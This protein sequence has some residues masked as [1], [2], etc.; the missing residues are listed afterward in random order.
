MDNQEFGRQLE[1]LL[2][3]AN[4]KNRTIAQ[5]LRYDV[6]YISK[7]ISGKAVPSRKNASDICTAIVSA[8]TENA[9]SETTDKLVKAYGV[10]DPS[11]LE[12]TIEKALL[13]AYY[14]SI[15]ES[16]DERYINNA[17]LALD[18]DES[19][20]IL[21]EYCN[22]TDFSGQI[23]IAIMADLFAISHMGK[24]MLSGIENNHFKVKEPRPDIHLHFVIDISRLDGRSV[25]DVILLIH[26]LTGYSPVDFSLSQNEIAAGKIMVA[27]KEDFGGISLLDGKGGFLATSVARDNRMIKRLYDEIL[28]FE[29]PERFIFSESSIDQLLSNHDYIQSLL[30]QNVRW[31][32]GKMTEQFITDDLF[33]QLSAQVFGDCDY[34]RDEARKA[35]M[36]SNRILEEGET[37]VMIYESALTG[38]MLFGELDFFNNKVILTPEQR[39]VQLEHIAVL[40]SSEKL[41][42]RLVDGGFSDDFRF[43]TNPC[44]FLA[45][46][47]DYLRLDNNYYEKNI[48]LVRDRKMKD[49]FDTFFEQIWTKREDVVIEDK[50]IIA[51]KME[52]LIEAAALLK[53]VE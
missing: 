12:E 15:G 41:A 6:S 2:F 48:L 18:P 20:A 47:I 43:I 27:V 45:D 25:Y 29:N 26:M 1:R 21:K 8:I 4:V 50:D 32:V 5:V 46:S 9:N 40:L 38:L 42:V 49:V 16:A 39:K 10:S 7:W 3:A 13:D 33:E 31:L 44:V 19:L 23:D 34:L 14:D 28:G 35:H 11:H 53:K 52:K 30:S 37:R 24:L 36:L 17:Y 51:G 22:S